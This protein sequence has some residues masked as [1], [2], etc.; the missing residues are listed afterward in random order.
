MERKKERER[1]RRVRAFFF[2]ALTV[3]YIKSENHN[4][5]SD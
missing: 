4:K 2:L 3:D 1:E 5:V